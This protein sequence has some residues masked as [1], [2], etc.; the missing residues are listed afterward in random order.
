MHGTMVSERVRD[1][2]ATAVMTS[3]MCVV[4]PVAIPIGP[5]PI[6]L[7]N[8]AIYIAIY[9]LGWRRGTVSCILYLTLAAAGLPV[10]AGAVGGVAKFVGPT[11]GY[12]IGYVPMAI[13]AGI[14]IERTPRRLA[15]IAAMIVG[16][17]VCYTLGTIWFS[18]VTGMDILASLG[19]CVWPFIPGDL[20]KMIAAS[21]IG[22]M[23]KSRIARVL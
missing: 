21:Q 11:G 23:I 10:L 15:H 5:V 17:L 6:A 14:A 2:T 3:V 13:I 12:L 19:L 16:T 9:L 1:I 20:L 18:A 4:G 8:F 7:T 22:S